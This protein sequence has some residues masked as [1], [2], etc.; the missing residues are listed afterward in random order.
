MVALDEWLI[1]LAFPP[2]IGRPR[3]ALPVGGGLAGPGE[4][5]MAGGERIVELVGEDESEGG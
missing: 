1:W 5:G 4:A 3:G 2:G